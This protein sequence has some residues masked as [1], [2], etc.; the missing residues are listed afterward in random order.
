[1]GVGVGFQ[2]QFSS[3]SSRNS[4]MRMRQYSWPL[5]RFLQRD[6]MGVEQ[7]VAH[8]GFVQQNP[9]RDLDPFGLCAWTL[10]G[11]EN[12]TTD[13]DSMEPRPSGGCTGGSVIPFPGSCPMT[14]PG[15]GDK[16]CGM[17]AAVPRIT[18]GRERIGSDRDLPV[19]G[20][21]LPACECP[22]GDVAVQ[23]VSAVAR[24]MN[25]FERTVRECEYCSWGVF[26]DRVTSSLRIICTWNTQYTEVVSTYNTL[27]CTCTADECCDAMH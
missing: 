11:T 12:V 9:V 8:Y 4:D 2:G 6:P 1:M 24:P 25:Y 26:E 17:N 18:T 22:G 7:D 19:A 16:Y 10:V 27:R 14:H 23:L 15:T 13:H 20:Q 3:E 21:Q 5:T